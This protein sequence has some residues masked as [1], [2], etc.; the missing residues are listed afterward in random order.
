MRRDPTEG[1]GMSAMAQAQFDIEALKRAFEA[2]EA[3]KVLEFYSSDLEHIE[4]DAGAPPNSPRKSGTEYIGNAI[5]GAAQAGITLHMENPVVGENRAACTITCEFPDGRRLVS[6][7]I[8]DLRD[9]KIVRQ[10]D[11]Q[12][13]DPEGA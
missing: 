5:E 1:M 3:G 7:T 4:I 2:R 12:V 11:V 8:Y 10:L 6:N 13:T 9:G